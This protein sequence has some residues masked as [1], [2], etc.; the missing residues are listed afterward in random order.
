MYKPVSMRKF[1]RHVE[2]K[3]IQCDYYTHGALLFNSDVTTLRV[4][5]EVALPKKQRP[6]IEF[7]TTFECPR[8]LEVIFQLLDEQI[9]D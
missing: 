2:T 5:V 1:L 8:R 4:L 3:V 6:E 9:V 7:E